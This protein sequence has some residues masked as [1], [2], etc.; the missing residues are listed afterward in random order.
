[1]RKEGLYWVK[2]VWSDKWEVA[3]LSYWEKKAYWDVIGQEEWEDDTSFSEI[4]DMVIVPE[5]YQ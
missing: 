4:G 5:K 2:P 3:R 1:M